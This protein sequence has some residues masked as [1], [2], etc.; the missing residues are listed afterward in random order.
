MGERKVLNKYFPP[1]F[2]PAWVPKGKR[3]KVMNIR[4]ML[5][6]SIQC[7]TCGEFMYAGKKFNSRCEIVEGDTYLGLRKYRFYVKCC[8]CCAEISFKTD[9][10]NADYE[11]E[12]GATRNFEA[13]KANKAAEQEAEKLRQ[14]ED[15]DTVK[16]LENRALDSKIEMDI[17]DALDEIKAI[18]KRHERVDPL[19]QLLLRDQK[20]QTGKKEEDLGEEELK[21]LEELRAARRQKLNK[22]LSD[23][24]DEDDSKKPS[25]INEIEGAL[26]AEVSTVFQ[27]SDQ[28]KGEETLLQAPVVKKVKRKKDADKDKKKRKKSEKEEPLK[29]GKTQVTQKDTIKDATRKDEGVDVPLAGLVSYSDSG[30]GSED[31]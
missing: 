21:G 2:D 4:M 22:R 29:K 30:E 15:Q 19:H 9:P 23:S 13:W 28:T 11:L 8:V 3:S 16:A 12:A 24:E 26:K 25:E 1:D 6:F 27:V 7:K 20:Q 18:N 10:Q 5:P 31:S 17:L 14:E